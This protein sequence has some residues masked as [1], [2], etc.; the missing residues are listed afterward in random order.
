MTPALLRQLMPGIRPADA[1]AYARHLG[2]AMLHYEICCPPEKGQ[3]RLRVAHFLAQIGH[4]SRDLSARRESLY[5]T[6]A[7]RIRLTWPSRFRTDAQAEPFVRNEKALAEKVYDGRA[8]LGNTRPGDGWLM[9]GN[10][11]TQ[12]TG[13]GNHERFEHHLRASWGIVVP[14]TENPDLMDARLGAICAAWFW[15]I[16]KRLN[17]EADRN[18]LVVITERINGG[19]N[20]L[21]DRRA[22]FNRI[23]TGTM[24]SMTDAQLYHAIRQACDL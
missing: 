6:A 5:Y 8:D 3:T 19:Q 14:L 21:A 16:E 24:R 7:S 11:P 10:G 9:R 17:D 12:L 23:W 4:E 2:R 15:A 22:R 1:D 18:E 20:G 13:R